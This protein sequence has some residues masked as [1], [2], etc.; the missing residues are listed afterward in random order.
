[1]IK[2]FT[3]M[4]QNPSNAAAQATEAANEWLKA[5]NAK[6]EAIARVPVAFKRFTT[7]M[8]L[9]PGLDGDN[10]WYVFTITATYGV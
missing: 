2:T 3:A 7:T 4:E 9:A 8:T 5:H 10:D 1:M 6:R